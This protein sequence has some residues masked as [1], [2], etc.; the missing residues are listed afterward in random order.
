MIAEALG[1]LFLLPVLAF[2]SPNIPKPPPPPPPPAPDSKA[3]QEQEAKE[4]SRLAKRKGR[5][6]TLLSGDPLGASGTL[7]G[8]AT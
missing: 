7:G 3:I 8:G 5:G 2:G 1:L 4:R 6:G